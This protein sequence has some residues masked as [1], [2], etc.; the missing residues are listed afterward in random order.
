MRKLTA[1]M[2]GLVVVGILADSVRADE[3]GGWQALENDPSCVVWNGN[4]QEQETVTWTGGCVGGKAQ[5]SGVMVWRFIDN[6]KWKES[7]YEGGMVSGKMERR[8][9]FR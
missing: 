1:L 3:H 7:R 5:G 6:G 2:L 8:G 9:T 4:P